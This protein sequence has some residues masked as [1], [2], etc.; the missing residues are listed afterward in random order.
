MHDFHVSGFFSI[1]RSI[2][3]YIL[4]LRQVLSR[5]SFF[6]PQ[7]SFF[8]ANEG[9]KVLYA[10]IRQIRKNHLMGIYILC[11]EGAVERK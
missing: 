3:L 4:L 7:N 8:Y 1:F 2:F 11:L 10:S 6:I 5:N 9:Y